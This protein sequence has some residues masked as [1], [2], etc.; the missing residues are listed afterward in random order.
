MRSTKVTCCQEKDE[1]YTSIV[2]KEACWHLRRLM[3]RF[4]YGKPLPPNERKRLQSPPLAGKPP[5]STETK[6]QELKSE[7]ITSSKSMSFA[8][9]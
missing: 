3:D 6:R 7:E 2:K 9:Q 8:E 5:L 4:R 1:P